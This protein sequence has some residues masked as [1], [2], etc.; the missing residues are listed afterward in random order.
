M[1]I[2]RECPKCAH[3]DAR[4]NYCRPLDQLEL[5]CNVC[6]Y[7]WKAKPVDVL[8]ADKERARMETSVRHFVHGGGLLCVSCGHP[9]SE[10]VA[11]D[12]AALCP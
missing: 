6:G 2:N 1:P 4:V 11:T 9:Q 10:H 12:G 3:G 5:T 7:E 8:Q